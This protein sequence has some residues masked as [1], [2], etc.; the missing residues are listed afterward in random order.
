MNKAL[1]LKD[2]H[3][4]FNKGTVNEKVA[5]NGLSIELDPPFTIAFQHKNKV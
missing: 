4:V 2:I 1:V 5:L 3:K